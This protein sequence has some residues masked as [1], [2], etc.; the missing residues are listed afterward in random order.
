MTKSQEHQLVSDS[1]TWIQEMLAHLKRNH[2]I[3]HPSHFKTLDTV[4]KWLDIYIVGE[5]LVTAQV[6]LRN[7]ASLMSRYCNIATI[8]RGQKYFNCVTLLIYCAYKGTFQK[9][10]SGFFPLRGGE[11]T[12]SFR[13]AFLGTMTFC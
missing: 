1:R 6:E 13:Y 9:L 4:T 3:P 7:T 2:Y 11:G 8:S 5:S 12:P 10:V